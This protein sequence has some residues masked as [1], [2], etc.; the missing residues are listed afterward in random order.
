M[1]KLMVPTLV[2]QLVH[3]RVIAREMRWVNLEVHLKASL[4][5]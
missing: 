4:K 3:T 2:A 1:E 5:V